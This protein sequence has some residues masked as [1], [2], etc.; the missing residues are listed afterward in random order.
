MKQFTLNSD[1]RCAVDVLLEALANGT[2]ALESCFGKASASMQKHIRAAEKLF[3]LLDHMP[4]ADPAADLVVSTMKFIK[5]HEH[6]VTEP[7]PVAGHIVPD[8]QGH[9]PTH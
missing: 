7:L 1:D 2:G 5:T 9:R 6:D 3:S 8:V 4:A